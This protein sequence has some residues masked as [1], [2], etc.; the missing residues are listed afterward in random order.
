[1]LEGKSRG[2]FVIHNTSQANCLAL[3]VRRDESNFVV[4][5][6][7]IL[8]DSTGVITIHSPNAL[9]CLPM[10]AGW[11]LLVQY[12]PHLFIAECHLVFMLSTLIFAIRLH[13]ARYTP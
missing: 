7:L 4:W 11:Y 12:D 1:M 3:V 6:G 9:Q 10:S 8:N 5:N 2:A 13:D